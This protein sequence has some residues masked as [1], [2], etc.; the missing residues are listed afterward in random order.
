[1]NFKNGIF[2]FTEFA[3][4]GQVVKVLQT[5]GHFPLETEL[6]VVEKVVVAA[7]DAH[8]R[9]VLDSKFQTIRNVILHATIFDKR[10]APLADCTKIFPIGRRL[11][12]IRE[13]LNAATS[14]E[15][16][17]ESGNALMAN[18]SL[19]FEIPTKLE[20]VL[21][22][23]QFSEAALLN[24]GRLDAMTLRREASDRQIV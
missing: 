2:T 21:D 12:T 20:A 14:N 6:L 5:V 16:G 4:S 24:V 18:V 10:E 19:I 11:E 23:L 8:E 3:F 1:M 13:F 17:H 15:V 22:E 7:F 9:V